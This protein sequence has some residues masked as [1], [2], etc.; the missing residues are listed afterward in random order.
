M[1]SARERGAHALPKNRAR[2][3]QQDLNRPAKGSPLRG[4]G[5]EAD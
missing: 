2:F 1:I 5:R 3:L 4:A